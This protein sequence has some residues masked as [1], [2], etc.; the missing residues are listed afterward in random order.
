MNID[1]EILRLEKERDR[2]DAVIA[3][4]QQQRN[5]ARPRRAASGAVTAA[6]AAEQA[7]REHGGPMRTPD[8]LAAV[9]ARG[10]KMKDADGLYKTLHRSATFKKAGRGLWTLA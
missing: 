3:Y 4:L 1:A 6:Q 9:Q 7:L 8:L 5:G 10:A 2:V